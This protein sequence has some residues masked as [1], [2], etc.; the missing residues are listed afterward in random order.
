[1]PLS[2]HLE[3]VH[4]RAMSRRKEEKRLVNVLL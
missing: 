3:Q 2:I 4:R 1:M